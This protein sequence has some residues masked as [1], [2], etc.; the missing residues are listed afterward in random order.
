MQTYVYVVWN[1]RDP[2]YFKERSDEEANLPKASE[3][4]EPTSRIEAVVCV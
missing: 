3:L 1:P 4:Q 2:P